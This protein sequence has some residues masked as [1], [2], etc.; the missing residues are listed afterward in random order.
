MIIKITIPSTTHEKECKIRNALSH[1]LI[2][3]FLTS[4]MNLN[5]AL[6]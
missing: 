1:I 2:F 3:I 4:L 5:R 6:K